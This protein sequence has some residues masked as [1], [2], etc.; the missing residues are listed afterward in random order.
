MTDAENRKFALT[1]DEQV[2]NVLALREF[3]A[4]ILKV[5]VKEFSEFDLHFIAD[6]CIP[7]E[8]KKG[9]VRVNPDV[10][11]KGRDTA[12][13]IPD[14]KTLYYDICF[15][16]VVPDTKEQIELI[17]NIEAQNDDHPGYS[18]NKRAQYYC[19]RLISGQL[20]WDTG[21]RE[22]GGLK[23]VYSIWLCPYA[24]EERSNTVNVY[25]VT[26][27]HMLGDYCEPTE[28]YD[29]QTI[30][31]VYFNLNRRDDMT[32]EYAGDYTPVKLIEMLEYLLTSEEDKEP[33][34]RALKE[35]YNIRL[36]DMLES[37]VGNMCNLS[38][39][40]METGRRKGRAEGIGIG[41]ELGI[42]IGRELGITGERYATAAR[43][44]EKQMNI[45]FIRE[46]TELS[47]EQIITYAK[48][49][50]IS[51]SAVPDGTETDGKA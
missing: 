38:N 40:V 37:E 29:L 45:P 11:V 28:N 50:G 30:V 34:L 12:D 25:E 41:R 49:N 44:L 6:N 35:K 4:W 47:E 33:K 9:S 42:G 17:V 20:G 24:S 21:L 13:K 3:L 5:C 7:D 43:L 1:Y 10:F 22:Y 14:E 48:E 32:S 36:S 26:E 18:L 46:V 16:A 51:I 19:S 27:T 2:R 31:M 39:G 15:T 23:K 8:P